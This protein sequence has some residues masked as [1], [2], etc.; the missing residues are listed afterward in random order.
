M[1]GGSDDRGSCSRPITMVSGAAAGIS[2]PSSMLAA[3]YV[4]AHLR[5]GGEYGIDWWMQGRMAA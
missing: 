3:F 4:V 2:H 5:G 1:G